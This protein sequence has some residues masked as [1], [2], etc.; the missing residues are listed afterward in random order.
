MDVTVFAVVDDKT[1]F[2]NLRALLGAMNDDPSNAEL[3]TTLRRSSPKLCAFASNV[4]FSHVVPS[5]PST[6][7]PKGEFWYLKL[8]VACYSPR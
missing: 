6:L 3:L 8:L 7:S 1:T 5:L 4:G 2:D